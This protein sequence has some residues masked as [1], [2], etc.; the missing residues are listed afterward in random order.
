MNELK[1]DFSEP[2]SE[3]WEKFDSS[4]DYSNCG[5][6]IVYKTTD[7]KGNSEIWLCFVDEKTHQEHYKPIWAKRKQLQKDGMCVCPKQHLWLCDGDCPLCRFYR[8]KTVSLDEQADGCSEGTTY[9]DIVADDLDTLKEYCKHEEE[10]EK[11]KRFRESLTEAQA[12]RLHYREENPDI[13]L[14]EIA[15]KE[16]VNVNAVKKTFAQLEEK[17]KKYFKS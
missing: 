5:R 1:K 2:R 13:T 14:R 8:D 16:R 17:F 10:N 6:Y 12:R 4:K 3:R 11:V 9:V 7:E 15:R